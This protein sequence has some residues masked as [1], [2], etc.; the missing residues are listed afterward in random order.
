MISV[1]LLNY[2]SDKQ[3]Y[4]Y[5][6][7]LC[8]MV[9]DDLSY[10]IVDNSADHQQWIKLLETFQ[11]KANEEKIITDYA[12]RIC[13]VKNETNAGYAKGN[14]IGIR[15]AKEQFDCDFILVSN[16]DLKLMQSTTFTDWERMLQED[17]KIAIIGPK[18]E[19]PSG[20][21]QSPC[22]EMTFWERW[23]INL[24]VYPFNRFLYKREPEV[25]ETK[26]AQE[27]FRLQGSFLFGSYEKLK[28]VGFFDEETFLYG[29]EII[30]AQRL[31]DAG[32]A[33]FYSPDISILHEHNQVIG[34]YYS[35]KKRDYMKLDSE[36]YYY[37][38]YQKM[39]HIIKPIAYC[40][41]QFYCWKKRIVDIVKK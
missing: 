8:E 28:S 23:C 2:F 6:C 38:T 5:Y 32:M 39:P 10:V 16:C 24:L 14:N 29:E 30:L 13:F 40:C 1:I 3:T 18:I 11:V 33:M 26:K 27:V 19:S 15:L 36:L 17:K 7:H 12:R 31:R 9:K 25:I 34:N 22:R 35:D 41:L 37:C 21:K 4:A 20:E